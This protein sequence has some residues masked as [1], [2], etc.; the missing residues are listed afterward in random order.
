LRT[1]ARLPDIEIALSLPQIALA[2]I[3]VLGVFTLIFGT[4]SATSVWS[5][6]RFVI[7]VM[8]VVY[9]PGKLLLDAA[10][11]SLSP[12]EDLALALVLGMVVS[13]LIFWG[14]AFLSLA[15]L[16][17]LWP[18]AATAAYFCRR[19]KI[20]SRVRHSRFSVNL[21][22]FLLLGV[23]TAGLLPMAA[24]PMYYRNLALL[25][26]GAMSFK[27]VRDSV[28][29]LSI[30]QEL[31]L[32]VPPQV[33]FLAGQPLNYHYAMDLLAAMLSR[34]AWLS[35][36]DLTVRFLPTLFLVETVLAVF[37]FSRAWLKSSWGAVITS[38]LVILGEDF[39]FIP[40]LLHRS[41]ATWSVE[42]FG[43]P[44]TYSLYSMNPMLPALAVLFA[45][46]FCLLRFSRENGRAWLMLTALL[47]AALTEYK[48][49]S[50]VHVLLALAVTALVY[51]LLHRDAASLRVLL[52]T[53]LLTVPLMLYAV[54]GT[55]ASVRVWARIEPWPYIPAALARM[56]LFE[57]HVDSL[58]EGGPITLSTA[59][60]LLLVG[61][62]SYLLGSLG[63]RAIA[64]PQVLRNLLFPN[65]STFFGFFLGV[66]A[67]V[68]P[69]I[70]LTCTVT[71][72]G[73]PTETE[74][75]NAV[76]FYV[77]SKYIIWVLATGSILSLCRGKR[78]ARQAVI[79]AAVIMLAIPSSAQF[80]ARLSRSGLSVVEKGQLEAIGYLE[81]HCTNGEVVL[82]QPPWAAYLVALSPCRVPFASL[83]KI[84]HSFVS[85]G[86]LEQRRLDQN[87][88]WD[89]WDRGILRTSTLER[90]GISYVWPASGDNALLS[91]EDRYWIGQN[92][93]REEVVKVIHP[94]SEN[95]DFVIYQISETPPLPIEHP[96]QL[97]MANVISLLGSSAS[98]SLPRPGA[99]VGLTLWWQAL[100]GIERDYTAFI[101]TVDQ[102][103][104]L[105]AQEDRVLSIG[106]EPTSEWQAGDIARATYELMLPCDMPAG[107]YVIKAGLYYWET[108]ERLPAWDGEGHRLP[109]DA[110]PVET[111]TVQAANC[112][113]D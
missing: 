45:G 72:R 22:H 61:L 87:R 68:G 52:L 44:T 25:P 20:W 66:L 50:A 5:F 29:H 7:A 95:R 103:G 23:I 42:Y 104:S 18:L 106:D 88:F 111:I 35:I 43:V 14:T 4:Y 16:F 105:W 13:S 89:A 15:N 79:V 85:Q 46:L 11:L 91:Y 32:S 17:V 57:Q 80:F 30:A 62:P 37:A 71:P 84:N 99:T 76:W 82:A 6:P 108:G 19:A 63:L 53:S 2:V 31:T 64:I 112:S 8:V 58:S 38:F 21:S 65:K 69:L 109:N 40:G 86:E 1:R 34:T 49:F 48:V 70:S 92:A 78:P 33:P 96:A 41:R 97:N 81:E 12:L 59:S 10:R 67:V 51:L 47:F 75:N 39:S 36:P 113:E 55:E 77:Q 107:N 73:Y 83:G 26:E 90:Y 54:F 98:T 74:Y 28:F 60:A 27:M 100:A 94:S 93:S 9:F 56:G 110:F 3:A 101:H 102:D 24:L